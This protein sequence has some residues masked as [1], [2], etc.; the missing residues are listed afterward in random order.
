MTTAESDSAGLSDLF[1]GGK[2][3]LP[4]FIDLEVTLNSEGRAEHR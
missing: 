3:L 2:E 4:G 1:V